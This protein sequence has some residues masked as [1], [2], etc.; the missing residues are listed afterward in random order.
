MSLVT[1]SRHVT[2]SL[3]PT[4]TQ[5]G[6]LLSRRWYVLVREK[7][8]LADLLI[9]GPIIGTAPIKRVINH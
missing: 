1:F 4:G 7:F 2:H 3:T 6:S 8:I 9:F 5:Y